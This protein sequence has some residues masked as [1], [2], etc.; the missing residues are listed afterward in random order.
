M[1][2]RLLVLL[3]TVPALTGC[4]SLDAPGRFLLIE[5]GL[6]EA[7]AVSSDDAR[8]WVKVFKDPVQG[9]LRFWS[10]VLQKDLVEER[11]YTLISTDTIQD[12]RSR[13]GFELLTEVTVEGIPHRYLVTLFVREGWTSNRI[14]CARYIAPK[15]TFDTHLDD[16]RKTFSNL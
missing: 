4:I 13:D 16:V 7:K 10:E 11:G 3:L 6:R 14:V 1:A 15:K 2:R 12:A 5:K 8:I 9:D